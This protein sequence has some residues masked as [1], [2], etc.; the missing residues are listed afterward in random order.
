MRI[1]HVIPSLHPG[2][3]ER[4]IALHA[5]ALVARG[6]EITIALLREGPMR[7]LI[8]PG[9]NVEHIGGWSNYDP[10]II[11]GIR[12]LLRRLK[13]D[14][15]QS[16]L[17]QMDVLVGAA[18]RMQPVPWL[19]NER[20]SRLK[21]Q[22]GLLQY[23]MRAALGRRADAIVSNSNEGL[24]YW[25]EVGATRPLRRL[26]P[27]IV[28]T[29]S[30]APAEKAARPLI[31]YVGR[32]TEG[33]NVPVLVDALAL[34]PEADAIFCGSGPLD[35][36]LR[37]QV[38][39]RGLSDRVTFAG[40]VEDVPPILARA[41]VLVL[42]SDFEGQP[43]AVLEAMICGCPVVVSDI[44]AHRELLDDDC[45][46]FVDGRDPNGVA[47]AL[48]ATLSDAAKAQ[49]RAARARERSADFE[50]DRV[51]AAYEQLYA[52]LAGRRA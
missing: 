21:Y 31:A 45:A 34:V 46:I 12:G 13:P 3:A 43:N 10:R 15:V 50:A 22:G 24:R 52:E 5:N 49:A 41:D 36:S 26:I 16:W 14:V 2:G 51:A 32:L 40:F 37:A 28:P 38:A 1:L 35:A 33:K 30:L 11:T 42:L 19:L 9:V 17:P 39:A 48:A 27:N 29:P 4:Q 25:D 8:G 47:Q 6:H 18:T 20:S 7:S 44:P 23:R